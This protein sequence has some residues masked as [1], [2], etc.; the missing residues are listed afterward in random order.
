[1]ADSIHELKWLNALGASEASNEFSKCCGSR[2]WTRRM[3][4]SRPFLDFA[5]LSAKA[6]EVWWKLDRDDW[7]EAFHSHPKIGGKKSAN[8]VSA[9]SR[10]WSGQEQAGVQNSSEHTLNEL[11]RLNQDYQLKFGY[12]FIVCATGKSA[13]EMLAILKSRVGNDELTELRIA[14][15]EQEKITE[16][17]L[18]KLV[19]L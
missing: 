12:I 3:V 14:A 2:N 13:D 5:Q 11:A 17:R 16:I 7:L 10:V 6:S 18:R 9:Q 19:E 1:M 15:G 4:E 8:E